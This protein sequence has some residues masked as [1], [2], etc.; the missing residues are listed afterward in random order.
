MHLF[1]RFMLFDFNL[2]Y[3]R[4]RV[5]R[6]GIIRR[7]VVRYVVAKKTDGPTYRSTVSAIQPHVLVISPRQIGES[8]SVVLGKN[9]SGIRDV[10][11]VHV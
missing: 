10:C 11:I 8:P 9:L 2:C 5:G 7:P 3:R 6:L 1:D 4:D